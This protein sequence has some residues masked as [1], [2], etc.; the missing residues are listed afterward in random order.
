MRGAGIFFG[1][2]IEIDE[3]AGRLR[4]VIS[5]NR[6]FDFADGIGFCSGFLCHFLRFSFGPLRSFFISGFRVILNLRVK[7]SRAY[8]CLLKKFRIVSDYKLTKIAYYWY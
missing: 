3:A 1:A 2:N 4:T 7:N 5:V 8:Q 6:D